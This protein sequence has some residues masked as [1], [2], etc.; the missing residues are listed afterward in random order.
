L[1]IFGQKTVV[2]YRTHSYG[3]FDKGQLFIQFCILHSAFCIFLPRQHRHI[4]QHILNEDPVA[5]GGIIDENVCDGT[6]EL[7]VLDNGGARLECGQ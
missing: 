5:R 6:H 7:A 3:V 1:N 4:D 2:P